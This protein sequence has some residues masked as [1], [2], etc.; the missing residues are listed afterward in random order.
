MSET[1]AK[2]CTYDM[3]MSMLMANKCA[4]STYTLTHTHTLCNA[5]FLTK[6]IRGYILVKRE[7]GRIAWHRK[8]EPQN[9]SCKCCTDACLRT[10]YGVA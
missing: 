10:A 6:L 4:C 3:R 1:M 9:V 8:C 7:G 5:T 2:C